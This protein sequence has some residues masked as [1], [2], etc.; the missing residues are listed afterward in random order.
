[1][2][3]VIK[4]ATLQVIHNRRV[5]LIFPTMLAT[6]TAHIR[7]QRKNINVFINI[8]FQQIDNICVK[9]KINKT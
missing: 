7:H 8:F 2:K 6:F 9:S 5:Y 1:M 3:Q 4:V